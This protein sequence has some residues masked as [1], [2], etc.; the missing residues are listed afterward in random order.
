MTFATVAPFRRSNVGTPKGRTYKPNCRI[1]PLTLGH[2]NAASTHHY[3]KLTPELGQ[4]ASLRFH[5]R[6][7]SLLTKGG[8]A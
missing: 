6:F 7:A 2:I 5:Q 8:I 1:W 4:A 3:L